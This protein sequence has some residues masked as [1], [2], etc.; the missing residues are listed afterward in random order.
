MV[1]EVLATAVN[2]FVVLLSFQPGQSSLS[3]SR[4][5]A[6][7]TSGQSKG[8]MRA[9]IPSGSLED[10]MLG[11]DILNPRDG[12]EE[13]CTWKHQVWDGVLCIPPPWSSE[14]GRGETENDTS[15]GRS[16]ATSLECLCPVWQ[17]ANSVTMLGQQNLSA[18]SPRRLRIHQKC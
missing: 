6:L 10:I 12:L 7:G 3:S 5:L 17:T 2:E 11:L 14:R 18:P 9:F 8:R 16:H 13:G 1:D 15:W 4:T